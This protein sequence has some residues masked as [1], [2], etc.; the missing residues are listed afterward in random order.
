MIQYIEQIIFGPKLAIDMRKLVNPDPELVAEIK[1]LLDMTSKGTTL[2]PFELY[3]IND[4]LDRR[5]EQLGLSAYIDLIILSPK[6][7]TDMKKFLVAF[8][9]GTPLY[10]RLEPSHITELVANIQI[11]LD[12]ASTGTR[13][14]PRQFA[15]ISI[16]FDRI[17]EQMKAKSHCIDAIRD[18]YMTKFAAEFWAARSSTPCES[19][20]SSASSIS[21]LK[22]DEPI[23]GS[24]LAQAAAAPR[25]T[26]CESFISSASS[27]VSSYGFWAV[28][29]VMAMLLSGVA[30]AAGLAYTYFSSN[31][32]NP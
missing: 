23:Q 5:C 14:S 7:V 3:F 31:N 16:V 27:Y 15:E 2:N 4:V 21:P 19:S 28:S 13:L 22:N 32:A 24:R 30:A 6:L 25:I 29:I 9:P 20:I 17:E 10:A 12:M 11:L 8:A 26:P 1:K 18:E